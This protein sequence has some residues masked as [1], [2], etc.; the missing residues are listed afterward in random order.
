MKIIS[1]ELDNINISEIIAILIGSLGI[2]AS[3]LASTPYKR[4]KYE[5]VYMV[6]ILVGMYMLVQGCIKT[7][8]VYMIAAPVIE[9]FSIFL[10]VAIFTKGSIWK[11]TFVTY[12]TVE[13]ANVSMFIITLL[14]DR[15][16][17]VVKDIAYGEYKDSIGIILVELPIV[18]AAVPWGILWK[19]V[20]K[21]DIYDRDKIYKIID[22]LIMPCLIIGFLS[23]RNFAQYV[24]IHMTNNEFVAIVLEI[25]L[26]VGFAGMLNVAAMIYN[27]TEKKRVE[28]EQKLLDRLLLDNYEQYRHVAEENFKLQEIYAE[29]ENSN[30]R[31]LKD[32]MYSFPLTG[33]ITIDAILYRYCCMADERNVQMSAVVEPPERMPIDELEFASML[34]YVMD[35]MF[36]NEKFSADGGWVSA[37][38]R[39][40]SGMMIMIAENN[41]DINL[42]VGYKKRKADMRLIRDIAELHSGT[43][44]RTETKVIIFI[45]SKD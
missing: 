25:L 23:S 24:D 28:Q 37:D 31:M 2:C 16:G 7:G 39:C 8:G 5:V 1:N 33:S 11:N 40:R 26:A 9:A 45:P 3:I 6:V 34:E 43:V 14:L 10:S 18:V 44:E 27:R 22:L 21:T 19:R 38:V 29:S 13:C 17:K 12:L 4:K 32:N 41:R 35:M 15:A 42:R 30:K 36:T 20:F